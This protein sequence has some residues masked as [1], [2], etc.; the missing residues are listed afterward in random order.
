MKQKTN[1][2]TWLARVLTN[3]FSPPLVSFFTFLV[4]FSFEGSIDYFQVLIALFCTT[5]LPL[6]YVMHLLNKGKV[7]DWHVTDRRERLRPIAIT[8]V[9]ALI[10]FFALQFLDAP[11]SV[12]TLMFLY[13]SNSALLLTITLFWKVSLHTYTISAAAASLSYLFGLAA[14][15]F[16]PLTIAVIWARKKLKA[17][18]WAQLL[19]GTLLGYAL[20][21]LQV[22]V[23]L[24]WIGLL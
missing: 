18:S 14:T 19:M 1:Y 6:F 3:V 5:L 12:K 8:V 11:N 21:I 22:A 15:P 2:W 4:A 23:L 17:H 20:T 7:S 9:G 10:G 24:P 16:Y 13:F